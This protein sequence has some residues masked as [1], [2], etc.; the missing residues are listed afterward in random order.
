[1]ASG[2]RRNLST[3]RLLPRCNLLRN[4][5]AAHPM[6]DL[7]QQSQPSQS[8]GEEEELAREEGRDV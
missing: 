6:R 8:D 5:A 4:V 1:M 7:H 2:L 3:I